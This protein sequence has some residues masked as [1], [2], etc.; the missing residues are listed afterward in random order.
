MVNECVPVAASVA[1]QGPTDQFR[2]GICCVKHTDATSAT[3]GFAPIW[4]GML[5]HL[6][7]LPARVL[8]HR[9]IRGR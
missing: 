7:S 6:L 3:T 9:L 4:R 1:N 2:L 8:D 5:E